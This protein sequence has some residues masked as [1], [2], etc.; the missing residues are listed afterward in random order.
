MAQFYRF[1]VDG[2]DIHEAVRMRGLMPPSSIDCSW[3]Y[4]VPPL[5]GESDAWW[6]EAGLEQYIVSGLQEW[7]CGLFPRSASVLVTDTE[8]APSYS[9]NIRTLFEQ[10]P[11]LEISE[12][13]VDALMERLGG[14]ASVDKVLAYVT[15]MREG[16]K[17]LL[18]MRH[19][20]YPDIAPHVPGGGVDTNESPL[21]ALRRELWEESGINDFSALKLCEYVFYKFYK[22]QYQRRHVFEVTPSV[23]LPD[24]WVH[25]VTG[26]GED[27]STHFIYNW[28]PVE[29]ADGLLGARLADKVHLLM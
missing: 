26:H 23:A 28:I 11:A 24:R 22:R 6:T 18:I 16:R 19:G 21:D 1:V 14:H 7:Q 15:R 5:P 29:R 10:P 9:D 17:E 20:E 12:E 27:A 13:S 3:L 25:Q 8:R 2:R 4:P